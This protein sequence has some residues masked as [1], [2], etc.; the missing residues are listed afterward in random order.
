MWK[1]GPSGIRSSVCVVFPNQDKWG[2]WQNSVYRLV[3][4]PSPFLPCPSNVQHALKNDLCGS[5]N[6][7]SQPTIHHPETSPLIGKDHAHQAPGFIQPMRSRQ[8]PPLSRFND[9]R[10]GG[11]TNS[12][13]RFD[14][15]TRRPWTF[16]SWFIGSGPVGFPFLI[17]W[18][19]T[20]SVSLNG[21]L[22]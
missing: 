2:S 17:G 5:E 18:V 10:S 14:V 4:N 9:V 22:G 16:R 8:N 6:L 20:F 7:W 3:Q 1:S 19:S 21:C 15:F 11:G 13:N 12:Q